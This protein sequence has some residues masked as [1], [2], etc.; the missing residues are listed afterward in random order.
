MTSITLLH[1]EQTLT[2]SALQAMNKCSLFQK[3]PTFLITPYQVQSPVSLSIFR[4]FLS[5]LEGKAVKITDTNFR[6]LEWLCE[7]FGFDEFAAKLSKFFRSS[8]DSQGRQLR[9]PLVRIQSALLSESFLFVVNGFVIKSDLA[10]AAALFPAVR[11]QLS[12]DGCA[13]N[14]FVN[15]SGI[16]ATDIHSLQF[17]L[18]GEAISMRRSQELLNGLLG[19]VNL[20]RLF[21][22][23][24]KVD[25][26]MNLSDLT[27]ERRIDLESTDLSGFSVEALDSLLL[28]ESVSIGCEDALLLFILNLGPDYRD[29]LRHIQIGFL[30]QDGLSILDEHF[31]IPLES[32]WQS[33]AERIAN[34]PLSSLPQ[35][36]L[37][38]ISDFQ[39][40]FT[41]FQ[42]KQFSLLWQGSRDGFGAS[43]FHR[44]CDEHAN[45]L[46]V[47][48]D[49]NGNIFG[50]FTPV[51][52]ESGYWHYKADDSLKS[53]LFTLK[54]PHNIPARRFALKAEQK[55]RAI[56]CWS[57]QGPNFRDIGVSCNCDTSSDSDT[58]LFGDSYNDDT[59]LT[60]DTFFTGSQYFQVKE[61]EVFEITD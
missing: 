13:R 45:T 53:F 14:F 9:N 15:E 60:G 21:L 55:W 3:N 48:L 30:S 52:W 33:A 49:T 6:E 42:G 7:E 35:L 28:S 11:E 19:N 29:L 54:N 1:P 26:E 37:K 12:V 34:L 18:S 2:V 40:I 57:K 25:I 39:E 23:C 59:G 41:E 20:E 44:R 51:K 46:T 38:T 24:S 43:E 50:G 31:G 47:I 61:I 58:S 36:D 16:E 17:L 5:A 10:E 4:E 8:E 32:V 27:M 22:N 56:Y